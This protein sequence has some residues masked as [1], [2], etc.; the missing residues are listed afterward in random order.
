VLILVRHGQTTAN[1]KG[2]L[3]GRLDPELTETGR[4]QA[5]AIARALGPVDRVISSP[6]QRARATAEALGRPVEI[7]ERWI[8]IDYGSYDGVPLSEVPAELWEAWRRDP[9]FRPP[10]GE[11][12]TEV[13]DRVR[14]ACEE[15]ADDASRRQVV[16]VSHVSPIKAAVA[17]AL[18]V[19]D[20]VAWRMFL[21]VG[22][23]CRVQTGSR[24]PSLRSYND[25]S[26]LA[27]ARE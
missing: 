12:L 6:L 14:V 3:L 25:T 1:A 9:G 13:G 24:G 17:W 15:L 5:R 2:L 20:N 4:V 8:E 21:D 16:V 11:S 27:A 10:G 7:D 26:H 22:A 23:I 19:G 18:G